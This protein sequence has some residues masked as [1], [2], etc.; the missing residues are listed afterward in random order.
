MLLDH[1]FG[2]AKLVDPVVQRGDILFQRLL[3]DASTSLG[4]D[5]SS[6]L[7]VCA[8]GGFDRLQIREL[9][10]QHRLGTSQ[11]GSVLEP[12]LDGLVIA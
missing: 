2:H 11:H 9:V 7:D 3:L 5:R 8:I 4:F 1:G 12:D 6:Q 10:L